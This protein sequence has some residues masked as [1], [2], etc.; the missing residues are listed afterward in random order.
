MKAAQ[1]RG[2]LVTPQMSANNLPIVS[3]QATL[4]SSGPQQLSLGGMT[5]QMQNQQ[6]QMMPQPPSMQQNGQMQPPP[7]VRTASQSQMS[8]MQGGPPGPSKATAATD[9]QGMMQ[10]WG[11]SQLSKSTNA[12][13]AKIQNYVLQNPA[14]SSVSGRSSG[15]FSKS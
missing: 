5:P 4:L 1:S 8:Q 11:D 10:A 6:L 9:V 13:V 7:P 12:L 15:G 2:G 14:S 3:P